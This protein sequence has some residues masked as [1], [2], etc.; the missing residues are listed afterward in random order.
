M[1]RACLIL[2][3]VAE[4]ATHLRT[5]ELALRDWLEG[6]EEPPHAVFI[7]AVEIVLLHAEASGSAS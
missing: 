5:T 6:L 2:G 7:A 4:L 1:H 3:G